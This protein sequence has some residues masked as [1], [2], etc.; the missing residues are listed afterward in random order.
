MLVIT[1]FKGKDQFNSLI[2]RPGTNKPELRQE[3]IYN[4]LLSCKDKYNILNPIN[5]LTKEYLIELKVHDGDYLSFLENAYDSF[6]KTPDDDYIRSDGII[7]YH[8]SKNKSYGRYKSLPIWKQFGYY[9]DDVQTPIN[10]D[11]YRISMESANNCYVAVDMLLL[12]NKIYCLN[13]YPG[14]HARRDGCSGYCYINNP[15]VCAAK[16]LLYKKRVAVLD[17]D[18]HA[19]T[20]EIFPNND[21]I[22]TISIHADP[23]YE[24]PTFSGYESENTEQNHNI[25]FPNKATWTEYVKCLDKGINLIKN[26]NPDVIIIPFGGDTFKDDPDPSKLYGCSLELEDYTKMGQE[27]SKLN[28]KVVVTQEGGY[29]MDKITEIVDNFLI[30]LLS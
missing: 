12:H 17:L 10:S 9:C 4:K 23:K 22:L 6:L 8:F 20:H 28:K 27:I 2:E 25:I 21:Q 7:P 30:G 5:Q 15:Y 29:C 1:N 13:T 14:H 3:Y 18:Y 19:G 11:T 16:L 24:Y 26:F